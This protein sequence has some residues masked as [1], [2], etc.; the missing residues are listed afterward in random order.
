VTHHEIVFL[1]SVTHHV[2]TPGSINPH[3]YTHS[4]CVDLLD[5]LLDLVGWS[6]V[7]DKETEKDSS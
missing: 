5:Q 7:N 2:S 1:S 4:S 3:S 6:Q